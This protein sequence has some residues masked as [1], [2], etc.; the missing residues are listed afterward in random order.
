MPAADEVPDAAVEDADY[1]P[2]DNE[3]DD[4]AA[5]LEAKLLL[6]GSTSPSSQRTSSVDTP[7]PSPGTGVPAAAGA[8][9]SS[10]SPPLRKRGRPNGSR[11][12]EDPTT[13]EPKEVSVTI[14]GGSFDIDPAKL[15]EMEVFLEECCLA[16]MFAL[17]RGGSVSRLHLQVR[18][19]ESV[20]R[21][22]SLMHRQ[23]II[24]ASVVFIRVCSG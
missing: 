2:L 12:T 24:E 20:A 23:N 4:E 8:P 17:E 6:R 13:W 21:D 11:K 19:R 15:G 5:V 16:G 3:E 7:S 18:Y 14:T 10:A 9:V 1:L 22:G